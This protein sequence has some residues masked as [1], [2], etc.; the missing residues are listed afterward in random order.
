MSHT[1][2][3][4]PRPGPAGTAAAPPRTGVAT[5][6]EVLDDVAASSALPLEQQLPVLERAHERL[7][8]ALDDTA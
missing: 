3:E 5:V 2:P 4:P 1:P 7:R 6:D 8:A